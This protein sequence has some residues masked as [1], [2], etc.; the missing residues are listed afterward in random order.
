MIPFFKKHKFSY[1]FLFGLCFCLLTRCT[2][3]RLIFHN[4]AN[5]DD[6]KKFPSLTIQKADTVFQFENAHLPAETLRVTGLEN[7]KYINLSLEDF[8]AKH[9]NIAFLVIRNDSLLFE[10]YSRGYTENAIMTSFSMAKTFVSVLIGLAIEEG[11]INSVDDKIVDYLPELKTRKGFDK[12][13]IKHLLNQNSGIRF[14]ESYANPFTSDVGRYY[15]GKS[16]NKAMK[17][18]KVKY[19]PGSFRQY[20]SANTQLL[21]LIV[22]KVTEG[23][24]SD[25]L[26]EKI[27][28]KIGTEHDATWSTYEKE[29]IEKAFCCI[30]ATAKDFA[31]YGRLMLNKGNWNGKPL[32]NKDWLEESIQW[33]AEGTDIWH[34]HYQWIIG[35][36]EYQDFMAKGLYEQYIYMM[37]KKNIVIVS[38]NK[39][40]IPKTDWPSIFRQIVDQL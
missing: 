12:I 34:Y 20:H 28:S 35:L 2:P 6:Y 27:W 3:G 39:F 9:K 24:L 11:K 32:I 10:Q 23:N 38:F 15:Y 13:T 36:K 4:F 33:S 30:N 40:H 16:L 17:G 19:P 1:L 31:R 21:G 25:Y 8:I 29:P 26:G 22:R 14:K 7:R 5:Q 37:P 18:L